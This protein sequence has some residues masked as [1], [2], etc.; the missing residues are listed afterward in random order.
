MLRPPS[1]GGSADEAPQEET[2]ALF[3]E[4][5]THLGKFPGQTRDI[6]G[7]PYLHFSDYAKWR[8][9]FLKGNLKA[10]V[11]PGF[12]RAS[13]DAWVDRSGEGAAELAGVQVEK[14]GSYIEGYPVEECLTTELAQ[15]KLKAR[16]SMIAILRAWSVHALD[17]EDM[18]TGRLPLDRQTFGEKVAAW[19]AEARVLLTEIYR[20][21]EAVT[22]LSRRYFAGQELLFAPAAEFLREAEESVS[23]LVELYAERLVAEWEGFSRLGHRPAE[24]AAAI[25]RI[26]GATVKAAAR[27]PA[28]ALAAYLVDMAKA[29]AL[30][31]QGERAAAEALME[32]H[33]IRGGDV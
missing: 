2:K 8:G 16:R 3:E 28:V 29:E 11:L 27:Q 22:I 19:G 1:D 23:G 32:P 6:G 18:W 24:E 5:R 10:T 21:R 20:L 31:K 12:L 17:A 9:R 26:D 13:F 25:G 14:I 33:L 4:A 7:R 30:D 15:A